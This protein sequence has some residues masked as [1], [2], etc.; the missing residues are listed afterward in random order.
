MHA[1]MHACMWVY[2]YTRIRWNAFRVSP[3]KANEESIQQTKLNI[4]QLVDISNE[5]CSEL[6]KQTS[7]WKQG[8]HENNS[9]AT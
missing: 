6:R 5:K 2:I 3:W 9:F 4:M 1:C 8:K 7:T